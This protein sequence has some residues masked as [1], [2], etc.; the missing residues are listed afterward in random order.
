MCKKA[1]SDLKNRLYLEMKLV[2]RLIGQNTG[3]VSLGNK[4]SK[5][6]LYTEFTCEYQPVFHS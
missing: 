5:R 3:D 4:A 2:E 6:D 1:Q